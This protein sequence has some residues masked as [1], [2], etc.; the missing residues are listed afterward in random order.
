MER[1]SQDT[2]PTT[3]LEL[4]FFI[5]H[6]TVY[7]DIP[8]TFTVFSFPFYFVQ[9]DCLFSLGSNL[10]I[11]IAIAGLLLPLSH[12]QAAVTSVV[13]NKWF[14]H[15]KSLYVQVCELYVEIR[16]QYISCT[17]LFLL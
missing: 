2:G 17:Y 14:N 13:T 3:V 10:L 9:K 5:Q 1:I 6:F 12:M 15:M 16:T 7:L 11:A 8:I 4:L